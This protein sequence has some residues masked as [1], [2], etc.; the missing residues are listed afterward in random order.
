MISLTS[1]Q[2]LTELRSR[3]SSIP[4]EF[5][6]RLDVQIDD[7]RNKIAF[8]KIPNKSVNSQSDENL[9]VTVNPKLPKKKKLLFKP[10]PSSTVAKAAATEGALEHIHTARELRRMRFTKST[11]NEQE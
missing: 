4:D 5:S 7:D 8:V 10:P 2:L 1:R 11:R 6:R 9:Q 3:K